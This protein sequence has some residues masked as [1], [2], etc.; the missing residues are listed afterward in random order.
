MLL[1]KSEPPAAVHSL[2]E[3]L[4]IAE[5]MDKNVERRYADLAD[6]MAATSRKKLAELFHNL[7]AEKRNHANHVRRWSSDLIGA[8]PDSSNLQWNPSEAF[9]D[10]EARN[11]A[12]SRLVSPYSVF[13]MAVRDEERFFAFWSY[14]A[15][16]TDEPAVQ[17]AAEHMA[18][19]GLQRTALLRQERRRAFHA[20][21]RGGADTPAPQRLASKAVE[22]ER[23]LAKLLPA[24]ARQQRKA[25]TEIKR[26][27]EEALEMAQDAS[28]LAG[29][30]GIMAVEAAPAEHSTA[31]GEMVRL[32]EQAAEAYLEAADLA[33]DEAMV[34]R[35]Q[36]LAGR[37]ISRLS[38]LRQ[39]PEEQ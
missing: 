23:L 15:A 18:R 8:V 25:S 26:L 16:H 14:V 17:A 27:A 30:E 19:E 37:A 28:S 29:A 22:A 35:L 21:G 13:S 12:S 20:E 10:E 7:A 34:R 9:D 1:L 5:A 33:Q 3:L 38:L 36:A 2:A 11:A 24:L 4:A 39:L 6:H 31:L 32:S